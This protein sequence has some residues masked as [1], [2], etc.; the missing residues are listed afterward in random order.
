[1]LNDWDRHPGQWKWAQLSRRHDAP[2]EPIPR[3]RDK[4]LISTSG[5]IPNLAGH[6][7]Q[8][9]SLI[10]F[11]DRYATIEAL[12]VNSAQFDRRLLNGLEKPVWD[13]VARALQGRITDHVIDVALAAMPPE[14]RYRAPEFA[15]KLR[16]RRDSLAA[17]ATRFY[18][19]LAQVVD[20][21]ATEAADRASV[22]YVDDDHVD[23]Q[24]QSGAG[25]PYYRRR[26]ATQETHEVRVYLHGGADTAV[27]RGNVRRAIPVRIIGGNGSNV[28]VDSSVVGGRRG[29]A[30]LYDSGSVS[31]VQYGVDTLF[32]RRPFVR[33]GPALLEPKADHG[34]RLA[35]VVDLGI[36]HDYGIEPRVGL[37]TRSYEFGKYP[38]ASQMQLDG[39]Y[40][41][42]LTRYRVALAAD[43][44]LVRSPVHFTGLAQASQ[45]EFVNFHGY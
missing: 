43:K 17:F 1:L 26:F 39:Q 30:H 20:V 34:S 29:S 25:A 4:A 2:W 18:L 16:H 5:L 28:L 13:S 35:P 22:S 44:R 45:L 27:V 36:N 38:Y 33:E 32:S 15:E 8:D 24:L 37:A 41:V 42:K 7:S 12:T 6:L 19:T 40:S 10:A 31:G 21:H 3:D 11:T 14:F 9:L 23:V